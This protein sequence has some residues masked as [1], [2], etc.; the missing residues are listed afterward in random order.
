MKQKILRSFWMTGALYL[1]GIFMIPVFGIQQSRPAVISYPD[2]YGHVRIYAFAVA[3]KGVLVTNFWSNVSGQ[4]EWQ[5]ADLDLPPG[6]NSINN[7]SAIT[8][9][10]S[11]GI[12]HIDVFATTDNGHLVVNHGDGSQWGWDDQ[13]LFPGPATAKYPAAITDVDQSENR[14]IFVFVIDSFANLWVN[15][16]LGACDH[17]GANWQWN[18]LSTGYPNSTP[19]Y[20]LT[21]V[22]F[23][24]RDG[25]RRIYV[26]G[27]SANND[28]LA[29]HWDGAPPWRWANLKTQ[30][31]HTF[32]DIPTAIESFTPEPNS[33]PPCNSLLVFDTHNP[34]IDDGYHI[35]NHACGDTFFSVGS[36]WSDENLAA[37]MHLWPYGG[38]GFHPS[39]VSYVDSTDGLPR[40]VVFYGEVRLFRRFS[41]DN[42]IAWSDQGAALNYWDLNFPSAITYED[43]A[44][45]RRIYAFVVADV[46]TNGVDEFHLMVNYCVGTAACDDPTGHSWI[47]ADQGT[48]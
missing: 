25:T 12:Q 27:N 28:L 37:Q 26:F 43:G 31:G 19:I 15:Y 39:A 24:A 10:D 9:Q 47:W 16:C 45:R 18:N 22:P 35:A 40:T 1:S 41:I 4:W 36:S 34:V 30:P 46:I 7:P 21:A 8:Y 14:R 3:D 11:V 32:F 42:T 48:M 6:A 2:P 29:V 17:F 20:S 33:Q 38:V 5:W 44:G 23:T 13:S